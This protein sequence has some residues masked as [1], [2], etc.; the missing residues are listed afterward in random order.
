MGSEVGGFG[1]EDL[2][3]RLDGAASLLRYARIDARS[4]CSSGRRLFG[5][6]H[7]AFLTAPLQ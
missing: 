7:T 4:G 1:L 6:T 2:T 5:C 3:A